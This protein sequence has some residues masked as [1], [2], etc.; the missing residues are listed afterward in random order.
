MSNEPLTLRPHH[1]MCLTY[2]TGHG[3][4]G[5][6]SAHM[7]ATLAALTP[8]RP[9]RLAAETDEICSACPNNEGGLCSRPERVAGYDR[10][11]L[12]RCGLEEGA[13]LPFGAFTALVQERILAAGLRRDICGGCQWDGLCSRQPSRWA[14]ST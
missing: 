9:V 6:F 3:Y 8:E 12:D 13:A 5:A 1:G 11:V 10:A 7:A 2:F 14:A 4:S